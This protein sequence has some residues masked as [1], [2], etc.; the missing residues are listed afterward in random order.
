MKAFILIL[1]L[2]ILSCSSEET[3]SLGFSAPESEKITIERL[4]K[5]NIWFKRKADGR[6]E[7]LASDIPR[8]RVI[9]GEATSQIIPFGRSAHYGP[10]M[11]SIM[12]K[13]LNSHNVPFVLRQYQNETWVI[14]EE[15]HHEK[16]KRLEKIAEKEFAQLFNNGIN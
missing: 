5:E 14:W 8:I 1:S 10:E 16:V 9:Y 12:V 11:H 2:L 4:K 7:F 13:L 15:P 6:Y 3:V